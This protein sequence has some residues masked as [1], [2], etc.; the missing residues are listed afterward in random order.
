MIRTPP[1][2]I[3]RAAHGAPQLQ[4]ADAAAIE[5]ALAGR[6]DLA[7]CRRPVALELECECAQGAWWAIGV[8]NRRGGRHHVR[9]ELVAQ[10][11]DGAAHMNSPSTAGGRDD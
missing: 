3:D 10:L 4:V 8:S 5:A 6:S 9:P 1:V 7:S 11:L 2:A